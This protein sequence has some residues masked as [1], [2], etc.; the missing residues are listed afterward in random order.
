MVLVDL[1]NCFRKKFLNFF[2]EFCFNYF[3]FVVQRLIVPI[4]S[5]S[6]F[7]GVINESRQIIQLLS[8]VSFNFEYNCFGKI[9]VN[10]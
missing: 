2:L 4:K 5:S 3:I 9:S 8:N 7:V 6:Y 10:F 1:T